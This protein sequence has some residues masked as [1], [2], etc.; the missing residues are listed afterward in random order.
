[1][2]LQSGYMLNVLFTY[3]LHKFYNIC[4][5]REIVQS[6]KKDEKIL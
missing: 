4:A 3:I 6:A 1:M 2:P 5:N